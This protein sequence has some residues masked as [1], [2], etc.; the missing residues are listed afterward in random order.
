MTLL[1]A[2]LF[3]FGGTLDSDGLHWS[4][5]LAASFAAAGLAFD[6]PDLDRAFLQADREIA[7]DPRAAAMRLAAYAKEYALRMLAALNRPEPA[8]AEAIA[9]HFTKNVK[10]HLGRNAAL[11]ASLHPRLR[12]GVVSNFT[13]NLPLLLQEAGLGKTIDAL[14]C[15][16][17]EGVKKPDLAIFRLA[18][19]RL[20]VAAAEA[21]MVGDSLGNDIVPAKQLGLTTIWLCGDRSYRGGN[22]AAADHTVRSLPEALMVLQT[23]AGVAA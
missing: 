3:D 19:D 21:A 22:P 16:A 20:G 5:Q 12:F 23:S 6:R 10:A 15:S 17:A 14:V 1:S 18:L 4:T 2:A 13:T 7:L 11:L 8:A 9:Q